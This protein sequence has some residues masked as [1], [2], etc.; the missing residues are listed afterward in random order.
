MIARVVSFDKELNDLTGYYSGGAIIAGYEFESD[1][2][3]GE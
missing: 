1:Y 2:A 3:K